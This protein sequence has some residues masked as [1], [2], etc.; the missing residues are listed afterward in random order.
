MEACYRIAMSTNP[1]D[2][3][4][5]PTGSHLV[6]AQV[7]THNLQAHNLRP[8]IFCNIDYWEFHRIFLGGHLLTGFEYCIHF[9]NECWRRNFFDK[10]GTYEPNSLYERLK[11]HYLGKEA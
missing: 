10:N 1:D 11:T 2:H 4:W 7:K 6:D 9:W 5:G 8:E 3:P